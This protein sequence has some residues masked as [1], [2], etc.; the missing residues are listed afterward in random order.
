M[1][2]GV[3]YKRRGGRRMNEL[4]EVPNYHE[5]GIDVALEGMNIQDQWWKFSDRI[6]ENNIK[7][8]KNCNFKIQMIYNQMMGFKKLSK[9]FHKILYRLIDQDPK[10]GRF[11]KFS[12]KKFVFKQ[13]K[14]CKNLEC[15]EELT[16]PCYKVSISLVAYLKQINP[17]WAH[18]MGQNNPLYDNL[19]KD[20]IE[21]L[22]GETTQVINCSADKFYSTW[23]KKL[24]LMKEEDFKD[25]ISDNRR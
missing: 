23:A 21:L 5:Q 19:S 9:D 11:L 10:I 12:T 14:S 15:Y 6:Y 25:E 16:L 13:S 8:R 2:I 3:I 22:E 7:T 1:W 18:P 20:M 24:L 4:L 17:I